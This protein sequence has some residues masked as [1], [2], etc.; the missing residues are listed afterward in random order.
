MIHPTKW[1]CCLG[2][3]S[4]P[5]IRPQLAQMDDDNNG[6]DI[7]KHMQQHSSNWKRYPE[8]RFPRAGCHRTRRHSHRCRRSRKYSRETSTWL[9]DEPAGGVARLQ[10]NRLC[11]LNFIPKNTQ[12]LLFYRSKVSIYFCC[13]H[14]FICNSRHILLDLKQLSLLTDR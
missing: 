8:R 9:A 12:H 7:M 14:F 1:C 2:A 11:S 6:S 13:F 5:L 10:E 4:E 3:S